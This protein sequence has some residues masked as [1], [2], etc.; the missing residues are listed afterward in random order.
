MPRRGQGW[1]T[2]LT[3]A[4]AHMT[5]PTGSLPTTLLRDVPRKITS[6]LSTNLVTQMS[7]PRRDDKGSH[8]GKGRDAQYH[9]DAPQP[10]WSGNKAFV[11]SVVRW[12]EEGARE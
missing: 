3:R 7:R 10:R 11:Y 4:L 5:P 2:L 8:G 6:E 9:R 12:C 1:E